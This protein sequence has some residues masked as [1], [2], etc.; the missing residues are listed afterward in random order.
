M[1]SVQIERDIPAEPSV[2][3]EW[4]TEPILLTRW[5][6]S[7]AELDVRPG[8]PFRM[9][10]EGPDVTLRGEYRVVDHGRRL[11]HTWSWDHD[12]LPPRH[13]SITFAPSDVGAHLHID[14]EFGSESEG[15]DYRAGWEY[16]L[17]R[18]SDQITSG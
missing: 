12:D 4:F 16:F 17:G 10:W 18:L 8:G 5:W 3:F 7:E 15:D 9:Y 13:V 6:P 11:D 1:A 2:V 14:H